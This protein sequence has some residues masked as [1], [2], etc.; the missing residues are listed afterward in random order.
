MYD[1]QPPF[2]TNPILLKNLLAQVEQGAL[3][4]PDF[5]RGWV[6]DDDRIKGLIASISK[7]F[8]CNT[9]HRVAEQS[10]NRVKQLNLTIPAPTRSHRILG[11]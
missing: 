7:G 1:G 2:T 8:D 9:N 10:L 6:W 11:R 4:L 3:Q 5:Q